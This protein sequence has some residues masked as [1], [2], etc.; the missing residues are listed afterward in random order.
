M[1][2]SQPGFILDQ[3]T[4]WDKF[5]N[6]ISDNTGGKY[7]RLWIDHARRNRKRVEMDGWAA[8]DLLDAGLGKTAVLI[9]AAPSVRSKVSDLRFLQSDNNY[10]LYSVSSGLGFLL[11]NGIHPDYCMV[12][13]ADPTISRFFDRVDERAKDVTL[14]ASVCTAPE[15]VERWPGP[16]KWIAVYTSIKELNRSL[17]KWYAPV[18]GCG[19]MFPALCSQYNTAVA[20]AYRVSGCR[21]LI[22]VGNDLSFPDEKDA[23]YYADRSD[24]KDEWVRKPQPDIHGNKVYTTYNFMTLKLACEDYLQRMYVEAVAMEGRAPYFFNATESG[25]FGVSARHGN[26]A[27]TTPYGEKLTVIWQV[28]LPMAIR[29][30]NNIMRYGEPITTNRIVRPSFQDIYAASAA[31]A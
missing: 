22:F 29:Q 5:V 21:I 7:E 19:I 12:M 27:V 25:I 1:N 23:K 26:L 24:L 30:A 17:R 8:S 14:I 2:D 10:L 31:R 9:G 3:N 28:P 4:D 16:V 11:D 13:D 6:Q 15:I 18:N 20:A